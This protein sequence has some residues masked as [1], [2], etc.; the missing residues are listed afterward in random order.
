MSILNWLAL[1]NR[2]T[3]S[4]RWFFMSIIV[5]IWLYF[6]YQRDLF[7]SEI[8]F[9]YYKLII[10]FDLT[11]FTYH[12]PSLINGQFTNTGSRII[13]KAVS[14]LIYIGLSII[15]IYTFFLNLKIVKIAIGVYI[16]LISISLI[17]YICGLY[18]QPFSTISSRIISITL[19]PVPIILFISAFHFIT[20]S[21]ANVEKHK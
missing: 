2:Q 18:F 11:D 13:C 16:C 17:L 20:A 9:L 19:S 5:I 4:G 7:D 6:G 1:S 8:N 14:A 12:S 15:I 10:F 3:K 21:E